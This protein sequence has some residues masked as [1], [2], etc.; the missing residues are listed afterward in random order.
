MAYLRNVAMAVIHEISGGDTF[1]DDLSIYAWEVET[2]QTPFDDLLPAQKQIPSPDDPLCRGVIACFGEWIGRP[3][4]DDS[5]LKILEPLEPQRENRAYCLV[6]PWRD[7]AAAD[8]G[9]PLTGSTYEVLAAIAARRRASEGGFLRTPP[10]FLRFVGPKEVIDEPIVGRAAWGNRRL[11]QWVQDEFRH[12]EDEELRRRALIKKQLE[13]LRNFALYLNHVLG[14]VTNFVAD[15]EELAEQLKAWLGRDL[16]L[17]PAL[18]GRDPFKG[19]RHYDVEDADVFYGRENDRKEAMRTI[20]SLWSRV[21]GAKWYWVKGVSGAG[22]SSFLRAGLV[23]HLVKT[24]HPR[25]LLTYCVVKT[26]ELSTASS[27]SGEL[28]PHGPLRRLF[29]RCLGSVLESYRDCG[30]VEV[31]VAARLADFDVIADREKARWA[32]RVVAEHLRGPGEVARENQGGRRLVIGFDQFEEVVDL[33]CDSASGPPWES[34]LELM[35]QLSS[36]PGFLILATLREDRIGALLGQPGLAALYRESA[37][38]SCFLAFPSPTDLAHII[39]EPFKNVPGLVLAPDLIETLVG[40]VHGFATASKGMTPAS[41]LPLVSLTL[42]RLYRNVA[43]PLIEEPTLPVDAQLQ[44][45]RAA[46]TTARESSAAVLTAERAHGYLDVETAINALAQEAVEETKTAVGPNWEDSAIATLLRR[47]IAWIGSAE[48]MFTLRSAELPGDATVAALARAMI[49]RRLIVQESGDRI[50]LVHEAVIANWP[51]AQTW[52][53]KERPLLNE[54]AMLRGFTERWCEENLA[55]KWIEAGSGLVVQPAAAVL[56]LWFDQ[57]DGLPRHPDPE[58]KAA[59]RDFCLEVLAHHNKPDERVGEAPRHPPHFHLAVA[60]QRADIAR[61][62]LAKMPAAV[63]LKRS[64]ERTALFFPAFVGNRELT[65]LLIEHGADPDLPDEKQW[66]PIH[67]ASVNG[68]VDVVAR[69]VK[70]GA[71]LAAKRAPGDTAPIHLAAMYGRARLIEFLV[72]EQHVEVD[73][74]DAQGQTPLIRAA[75]A[76]QVESIRALVALGADPHTTLRPGQGEDFGW[77]A[78]H[79]AARDG[80]TSAIDALLQ[81]GLGIDRT[82]VNGATALHLAAHNGH[83]ATLR[84]L[85]A[86]GADLNARALNE[87]PPSVRQIKSVLEKRKQTTPDI[88]LGNFDFSPLHMAVAEGKTEVVALL[89]EAGADVNALTGSGAT[90]LSL[91][92][93]RN[94]PE[95]VEVLSSQGADTE[96]RDARGQTPFH[97]ALEQRAFVVARALLKA[98]AAIDAAVRVSGLVGRRDENARITPLHKAASDGNEEIL[99]FLLRENVDVNVTDDRGWT[100]LHYAAAAGKAEAAESLLRRGARPQIADASELTALHL[101]C[102]K[103]ADPVVAVLL[104]RHPPVWTAEKGTV[105]PLH[106]AAHATSAVTILELLK[107]GHPVDPRD[108]DGWTPLHRA[109]QAGSADCVDALLAAGA[110]PGLLAENPRLGA[111]QLAARTGRTDCI[112]RLLKDTGLSADEGLGD[113]PAPVVLAMRYRQFDAVVELLQAGASIATPDPQ[114]G[115]SL[116]EQYRRHVWHA[117]DLGANDARHAELENL[118]EKRGIDAHLAVSTP[119]DT[120]RAEKR[121]AAQPPAPWKRSSTAP[122]QPGATSFCPDFDRQQ[123]SPWH[124]VGGS[125][126]ESFVKKISPVDGKHPLEPTATDVSWRLLPWYENAVLIH[127]STGS[128]S[129]NNIRFFYLSL[130][131]DL[132]RLNGTSPPIHEVNAK[133]PIRIN[134]Q[135]VLDYLRF[136][137]FFV[138]GEQ[139]PFYIAETLDDPLLPRHMD[140]ATKSVIEGT[141]RPASFEGLN[142]EG[143]FLCEAV[144]YYSNALFIASLTVQPSGMVNMLDDEP[145]AADL[146]YRVDGLLS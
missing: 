6:H 86:R 72:K 48:Q 71:H 130:R 50:R 37:Q 124:S 15:E 35:T 8:G 23:G 41:L 49:Q 120:E 68:S 1:S 84:R 106:L 113:G 119:S 132:F 13:Q 9:F 114:T 109:A 128:S 45:E 78:L 103:G 108:P 79:L 146:P 46:D 54:V 100:P 136:F 118:F 39:R 12:D 97:Q 27:R 111:L 4:T 138:H 99:R 126:L 44:F 116:V 73:L 16:G 74:R 104:A 20:H 137:C 96:R 85:L 133:A 77:T 127:V 28:E 55:P 101:A 53:D 3:L 17:F 129:A 62:M 51:A 38:A 66:R 52:L 40:R 94:R 5:Y 2:A 26:A 93:T 141:V 58:H 11:R 67:A 88:T 92:A 59:L 83:L 70:A 105:T 107:A 60:Y 82:L 115:S 69:L 117:L 42:E 10:L 102:R 143:F 87:W 122:L 134:D 25:K 63:D 76:N 98:G 81:A 32:A 145:I 33:L 89:L 95:L 110:A 144:V 22:K 112:R 125:D 34:L 65:D 24:A 18:S 90:P 36:L 14:H 121:P 47:L 29:E 80:A 21:G 57:L 139:G 61:A 30:E 75:S 19:L 43:L 123:V 135:N 7:E 131:G 91:A 140:A 142:K 64:D 56:T 31:A